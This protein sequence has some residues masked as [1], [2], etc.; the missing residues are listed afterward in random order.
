[1]S[2]NPTYTEVSGVGYLLCR[3]QSDTQFCMVIGPSKFAC[4]VNDAHDLTKLNILSNSCKGEYVEYHKALVFFLLHIR[5]HV[6]I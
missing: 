2:E 3:M 5:Q 1:M 6:T 4:P